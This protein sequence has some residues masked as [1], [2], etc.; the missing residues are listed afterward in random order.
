MRLLVT[1]PISDAM[2][3]SEALAAQGHDVLIS[4][5]VHIEPTETP[6]PPSDKFAALALTSANGVRALQARLPMAGDAAI[7]RTKPAFAVGP[8]TAAALAAM[9]WPHVLT[10]KGDVDSLAQLIGEHQ[11]ASVMH[12]A[13]SHLAGDLAGQLAA[14]N[15]AY[16]KAVLYAARAAEG[17]TPASAMALC[18]QA[19]PVEAVLLYSQRSARLFCDLFAALEDAVRPHALCLSYAIA[20][21]MRAEGFDTQVA[22]RADM[23]AMLELTAERPQ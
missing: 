8:Q 6:L 5:M 15:I 11:P 1:R 19:E 7:W 2:P 21:L 20:E 4:P 9:D 22:A 3:L 18:D 17:F 12:I 13:G 23:A 10:A 16:E 14:Q